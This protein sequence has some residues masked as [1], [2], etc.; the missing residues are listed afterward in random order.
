MPLTTLVRIK[1]FKLDKAE[2]DTHQQLARLHSAKLDHRQ[3]LE[4]LHNYRDWRLN[5]EA[6]LFLRHQDALLSRK[7][8]EQ[9]QRQVALMREK[10]AGLEQAVDES[11]RAVDKQQE[12]LRQS[13][14]QLASA[15]QQAEKINQLQQQAFAEQQRLDE[16]KEA[17]ELE[18]FSCQGIQ[19]A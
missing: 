18:E 15:Q 1:H 13:Q 8:L 3:C 9:W 5:E 19:T 2:R 14:Q 16:H 6:L 10:E 17:L 4:S 12:Q 11:L 7:T